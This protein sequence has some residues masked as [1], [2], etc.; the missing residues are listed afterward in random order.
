MAMKIVQLDYNRG[1][2]VTRANKLF[3]VFC[4]LYFVSRLVMTVF[5]SIQIELYGLD[6][7]NNIME[8]FTYPVILFNELALVLL[9]AVIY[10]IIYRLN[11]P[12]GFRFNGL[13]FVNVLLVVL[14]SAPL[15]VFLSSVNNLSFYFLQHVGEIP[16]S[17]IPMPQ[18]AGEYVLSLFIVAFLPAVCEEYFLRGILLNAYYRRGALSAIMAS[19][20]FFAVFHFD[21]TNILAPFFFGLIIGYIVL[22]TDSIYA[23]ILAHFMNNAIA[24]TMQYFF[25]NPQ[26]AQT[27]RIFNEDLPV[28]LLQC[29]VSLAAILCILVAF[30]SV[31]SE[32]VLKKPIRNPLLGIFDILTHWPVILSLGLYGVMVYFALM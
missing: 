6:V 1:N 5:M 3:L 22:R 7:A 15:Y 30:K 4:L 17:E 21:L 14:L 9:P 13:K 25:S 8:D 32:N 2:T 20:I 31:N 16:T 27:V 12:Y 19:G 29:L 18:N 11:I 10:T 26:A 28:L 24:Q 23:G